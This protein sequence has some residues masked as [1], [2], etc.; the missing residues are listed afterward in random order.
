[1]DNFKGQITQAVFSLLDT[2]NINVCLL[3]PNTIDQLQPMDLSVNKSFK[4]CLRNKFAEW[5]SNEV[6]KQFEEQDEFDT[7]IVDLSLPNLK[8]LGAR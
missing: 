2:N 4:S 3:P 6:M 8:E 5:Y 1:M 7:N